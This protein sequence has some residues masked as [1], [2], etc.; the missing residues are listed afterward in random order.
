L[1]SYD[2]LQ[3]LPEWNSFMYTATIIVIS[4]QQKIAVP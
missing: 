4:L 3:Q 2:T 1:Q